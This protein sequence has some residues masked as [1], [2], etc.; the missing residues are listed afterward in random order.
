MAWTGMQGHH[1]NVTRRK[2]GKEE[3]PCR[4]SMCANAL[5]YKTYGVQMRCRSVLPGNAV[6]LCLCLC[7]CILLGCRYHHSCCKSRSHSLLQP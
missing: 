1:V 2:G 3:Q 7:R 6:C 5:W 4:I